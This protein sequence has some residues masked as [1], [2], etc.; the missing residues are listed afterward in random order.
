LV[1]LHFAIY[2][3]GKKS[4]DIL[5]YLELYKNN[6]FFL[7]YKLTH[8]LT[9]IGRG[10]SC[11]LC[12][13]DKSVAPLHCHLLRKED[14]YLLTDLDSPG[15]TYLNGQPVSQQILTP[16]DKITL[17][18][19]EIFFKE[20][21][22]LTT[23]K[24]IET[25]FTELLAQTTHPPTRELIE[26]LQKN[27]Q[28]FARS[29]RNLAT[30]YQV[31]EIVNQILPLKK[32]LET[33]L[34]L[35]IKVMKA[36]RGMVILLSGEQEIQLKIAKN[37]E[38]KEIE[39]EISQ[40]VVK[41]I[42]A[43][44]KPLLVSDIFRQLWVSGRSSLVAQGVK[45]VLAAPLI[46][47]QQEVLGV[48]Y[49]DSRFSPGIFSPEDRTLL[50][51][52][53]HY[54]SIA[55][56]NNL[57][58]EKK[59]ELTSKLARL[60]AEKKYLP[61]IKVLEEQIE[62]VKFEELYGSS[63]A[64]TEVF[65]IIEQVALTEATVLIEGPTGTGKELVAR[66]IHQ[67]SGRAKGPFV[68]INCGAIPENLLEAELFG[69]EKGAFTGASTARPGKF[70]LAQGGTVFLDEVGELPLPLQ[71]KLLRV[72]QE[73]EIERIG[74]REVVKVD[75]R[76]L[77]A[78]NKDLLA[79]V[80][81]KSFRE[82]LYYRLNIVR[83]KMPP[84]KERGGDI[85]LLARYFLRKFAAEYQ[86]EVIGFTPA[87]QTA[88]QQYPWPGNV[89]ELENKIRRAV[90]LTSQPQITPADL[91]IDK[92]EREREEEKFS[93][94]LPEARKELEIKY[95]KYALSQH[96]QNLSQAAR[97]IGLKRS[98]FIDLLKKYQLMASR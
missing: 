6:Q 74:G 4:G 73:R 36:E 90:L 82:D 60:E 5:F 32:L 37:I 58:V 44:R 57:L 89:R 67:R 8:P 21:E 94:P 81:D 66:A 83:I 91:E 92:E 71:V 2:I 70:E 31:G 75:L 45:T 55:I 10:N 3:S 11:D 16:G 47:R 42:L 77:A 43:D 64:M 76:L 22:K 17:G 50:T 87:A 25:I 40:S 46:S 24:K 39:E 7:K 49:L 1:I 15:G 61:R 28:I 41:R 59:E 23:E 52:F 88:L 9:T 29:H 12:L 63:P 56:E 85:I 30:L 48:I 18:C 19:Y 53:A 98:T 26:S 97:L 27:F 86:K 78:T 69:Y 96:P 80:K 38:G 79:A 68:V 20:E 35:A 72:L 13:P 34:E 33:I 84:L 95:L 54:A 62:Q 14:Q 93:L 65:K 51:N